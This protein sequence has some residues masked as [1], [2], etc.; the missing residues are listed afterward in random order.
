MF[1][2]FTGLLFGAVGGGAV[3]L[4]LRVIETHWIAPTF[5]ES[6]EVYKLC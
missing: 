3:A 4:V 5:T 6:R 1:A 2:D